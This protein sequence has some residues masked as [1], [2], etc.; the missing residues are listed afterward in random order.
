MK[1]PSSS[2]SQRCPNIEQSTDEQIE[3]KQPENNQTDNK[4]IEAE[5]DNMF[6]KIKLYV[7]THEWQGDQPIK[8]FLEQFGFKIDLSLD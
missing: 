8:T 7:E 6:D 2:D 5:I 4:Q 1:G 3:N